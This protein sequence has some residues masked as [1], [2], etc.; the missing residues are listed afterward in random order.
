M[1]AVS[2]LFAETWGCRVSRYWFDGPKAG[3]VEPVIPDLPGYPDNINRASDGTYWLALVGMR[4][5]SLDLALK[6]PGFRRRMARRIAPDE[7]LF[8]NINTGCV[9]RFDDERA[10]PR[11]A[12]GSRRREPS[13]DHL[14]ARAQGPS[15]HRRHPQQP[16]RPAEA[17]GRRSRAGPARG[18]IGAAH[19]VAFTRILDASARAR[20]ERRSPSRRSTARFGRTAGSTRRPR[21]PIAARAGSSPAPSG[22]LVS[23]GDEIRRLDADGA[24]DARPQGEVRHRLP[25]PG[26]GTASPS[27]WR[28]ATSR[29]TAGVSTA[30]SFEP[31]PEARCPTAIDGNRGRPLCLPWLGDE[32]PVG[33]A[34][35]SH[36]AQCLGIRLA[37]DPASGSRHRIIDRLAFPAGIAANRETL[38]VSEAWRH[39]LIRLDPGDRESSSTW[40]CDDLPG[41]PG[42]IS[43][44][45]QAGLLAVR[46]RAA[47]P[48]RRVRP[49][50]AGLPAGACWPRSS[51]LLGGAEL[52]G[53]AAFYEPLQ[54]GGRQASGHPEALGADHV[55]RDVVKLDENWLPLRSAS[56]A[57][58]TARPMASI[59]AVEHDGQPLRRVA[60]GRR[61]RLAGDPIRR[62]RRGAP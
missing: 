32:Q 13:D 46:L 14:D 3:T 37:L 1:T 16:H 21:I 28:T 38:I 44:G 4:T 56:R 31:T 55:L 62:T 36:G 6:M 41:Y 25:G 24:V 18:P 48:A 9:L 51:P 17:R 43:P 60:R 20:R 2:F 26:G 61:H 50:R 29:S 57:V 54:G 39:R 12:V 40:R 8:P 52:A 53:R 35:R 10:H 11:D 23:A 22:V 47:Q 34:T 27:G 42:Q 49:A 7:W 19:D 59:G 33:L 15:L 5:P 30:R 45:R 58:P